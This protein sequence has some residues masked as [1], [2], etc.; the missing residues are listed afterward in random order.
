VQILLNM[1]LVGLSVLVAMIGSFAALTHAQ[2][3]REST[4]GVA[5]LWMLIGGFTLGLSIWSMHFIGMLALHLPIPVALDQTLTLT[6]ALPAIAAALF[7]FWVVR[8]NRVSRTRIMVS[9]LLMGACFS[10][11]HYMGMAALKMYPAISY[12][13]LIFSL[14]VMIAVVAAWA[15]LLMMYQGDR[16]KLRPLLRFVLGGVIMGSTISGM[17][18]IAMLGTIIQPGSLCLSG[19]SSIEPRILSMLVSVT[20]LFWFAGGIFASFYDRR[21]AQ[22]NVRALEA[23]EQE[24]L[25]L[26]ADTE[27]RAREMTQSLRESE[28]RLRMTL[29]Y[30]PDAVFIFKRDGLI[31]YVNDSVLKLLGHSRKDL[32]N[33]T[34]FDLVPKDL[35]GIYR[36]GV[37]KILADSE[38]H[39]M[40]IRLLKKH[41][42]KIPMELNAVLL[43][44]GRVYGSCRDIT[45]RKLAQRALQDTQENLQRLLNSVA[46]GIYGLDNEGLCTFVNE[47]FLRILGY[48]DAGGIVGKNMHELIH[49]THADGS[50]Y[51]A[52]GCRVYQA[53]RE[54]QDIHVDDEVFWRHD[55]TVV[56]VEY[57]SH[58][59]IKNGRVLGAVV[60]FLDITER[61]LAEQ[62]IHQLAFFDALT[63]LPN[64]RLLM[65][66]LSQ[67]F[68]VS[69]RNDCY[70]ALMFLDLDHFKTLNDSRGHDV[71]D[72]LLI[73]VARR[74]QGC[75]REGDSVAR[76]GGDEFVVVLELLSSNENQ[77]VLQA[78]LVGEKIRAALN[79]P[80]QLNQYA[81]H[82]TPSIGIVLFKGHGASIDNLLKHADVAMYRAKDEG[83]NGIRFYAAEMQATIEAHVQLVDELH[84][85]LDKQQFRL[86]YQVQVDSRRRPIGAEVLLRWEHPERGL[87]SPLEFIPLAEETGLILPLGLWV[88]QT[89]CAQLKIWQGDEL[90][91]DLVLA[92]NVS[93][94]QFRQSDFVA[95]VQR[96]LTQTGA[97]PSRLKL[98]LTESIV[99]KNVEDTIQRMRELKILGVSFA[100][101]DFGTGYSSLQYLKRLPL[102]QIKI[103]QSFVRDIT[104]DPNDRAIVQT[105][106]AMTETM[107]LN[108]IAEGVETEAQ[109]EFL[110]LRGCHAFQG[111][112]FSKPVPLNAFEALL[113]KN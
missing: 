31:V 110:D 19:V 76:L 38:R 39:I 84:S 16:I 11:M 103:D 8:E 37:R 70:G 87:V 43:P 93:A 30:A 1:S 24:H 55:G 29:K 22:Q 54:R 79:L 96:V 81:H 95:E 104:T 98:E 7:G 91:R 73:E 46:E 14:S 36:Q 83:R 107:G 108:V 20:A 6:S 64:R 113:L 57:W 60:T 77:A 89:A 111:Y 58:P 94:S 27:Q 68:A 35:Q 12:N 112:L 82:T 17:H 85:A 72:L 40:E 75:V 28:M 101:D 52:K 49:H 67:A 69:D 109:L 26:Q 106:I 53:F 66:R 41:G 90:T 51:L 88:L 44:D 21:M 34:V 63:G 32:Y 15:T 3:M 92:V 78:E 33:M 61:K 10:L 99:L 100:M 45:E 56:S 80:Y 9:G 74:L 102:D 2:R 23:L 42:R 18:Y 5:A 13:P 4:G 59:I 105:V 97:N 86:Y 25:R 50:P 48:E 47:A 62:K 71:G 65:D